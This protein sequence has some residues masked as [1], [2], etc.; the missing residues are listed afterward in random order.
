MLHSFL[1][2]PYLEI[3]FVDIGLLVSELVK[4]KGRDGD[5]GVRGAKKFPYHN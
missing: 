5:G 4:D 3:I 1:G 2:F